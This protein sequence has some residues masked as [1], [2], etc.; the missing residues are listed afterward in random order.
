MAALPNVFSGQGR[1]GSLLFWKKEAKNFYQLGLRQIAHRLGLNDTA[2]I[3]KSFL[4]LFS[5]KQ[6]SFAYLVFPRSSV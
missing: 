4:L 1:E 2:H 6:T 5:K 3:P